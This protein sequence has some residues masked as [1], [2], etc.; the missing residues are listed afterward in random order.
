MNV[1]L[2]GVAIAMVIT[3]LVLPGRSKQEATVLQALTSLA[4]GSIATAE[5]R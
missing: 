4:T 5:G 3:S 2:G 1:I